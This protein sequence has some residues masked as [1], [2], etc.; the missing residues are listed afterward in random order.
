MVDFNPTVFSAKVALLYGTEI[1]PPAILN[2]MYN[3]IVQDFS[4]QIK[5]KM[6]ILLQR[7]QNKILE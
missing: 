4:I 5:T 7:S 1:R 3:Y 6:N 2:G